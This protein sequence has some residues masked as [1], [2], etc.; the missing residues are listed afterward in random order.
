MTRKIFVISSLL[1]L[2]SLLI[3][4]GQA[5]DR[6]NSFSLVSPPAQ[7]ASG[8]GGTY[9]GKIIL[10]HYV[11]GFTCEGQS[12][13]ESILIRDGATDWYLIRNSPTKCASERVYVTGV[14]YDAIANKATYSGNLYVPPRPYLVSAGENPNLADVLLD[15]GICADINGV[16]SLRAAIEQAGATASTEAIL[17]T[18]PAGTYALTT[19]LLLKSNDALAKAITIR[20]ADP[21]TTILDGGGTTLPL[22]IAMSTNAQVSIENLTVQNGYAGTGFTASAIRPTSLGYNTSQT[23]I[24]NC[25]LKNNKGNTAVYAGPGSGRLRIRKSKFAD[26]QYSAISVFAVTSLLV[27]D[28]TI[29]NSGLIGIWVDNATPNVVIRRTAVSGS[30]EKGIVFYACSYCEIENVTV[31]QSQSDGISIA[32]STSDPKYD[33]SIKNSSVVGNGRRDGAN[34]NLTFADETNKL[35]L[36]NS[37]F[38]MGDST[39]NNCRW[40]GSFHTIVPTGNIFDDTS[41]GQ[42][43]VDNAVANPKLGPL[44]N[45]GG[46]TPT[47]MPQTGSP[48]IDGGINSMCSIEDQRGLPRPVDRLGNGARCD[49]GSVEL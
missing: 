46:M 40:S 41:C 15:D 22:T 23:D 12:Q 30:G 3:V 28:T 21:L 14:Q 45:N 44:T 43:S 31:T 49:V 2:L 17:V 48:A 38:A 36:T 26:N 13:P 9:D 47:M 24:T 1:L 5:C 11:D 29:T 35:T 27:E 37:I 4:F 18:I 7:S 33:V 32:A 42:S 8:N 34:L 16:C 6:N 19:P 10:H 20:G 25:I 39:K